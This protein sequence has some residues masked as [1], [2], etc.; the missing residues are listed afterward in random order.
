LQYLQ[1]RGRL[2]Q[3]CDSERQEAVAAIR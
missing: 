2:S 3:E 1:P